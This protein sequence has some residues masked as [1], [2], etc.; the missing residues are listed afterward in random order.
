MTATGQEK[1]AVGSQSTPLSRH[2]SDQFCDNPACRDCHCAPCPRCK[3]KGQL[4]ALNPHGYALIT[5]PTCGGCG[6]TL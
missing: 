1:A 6:A 3:G 2:P 5:C 4:A